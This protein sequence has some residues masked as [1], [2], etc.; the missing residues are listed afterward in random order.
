M[1][2]FSID[3]F[4]T[5]AGATDVG[6]RRFHN[7]DAFVIDEKIGLIA[8]ADGIG[9]RELGEVASSTAINALQDYLTECREIGAVESNCDAN[10]TISVEGKGGRVSTRSIFEQ[11]TAAVCYANEKIFALNQ[12]RGLLPDSSM[13]TT[14]TGLVFIPNDPWSIIA[15]NLGDSRLYRLRDR[16]LDQL[17]RD[18]T[19]HQDWLDS[20]RKG[21][22][23]L[24]NI[25]SQC[26]GPNLLVQ[27][28]VFAP[29]FRRG[30]LLLL[31]SDGLS[32]L[33]DEAEIRGR[34]LETDRNQLSDACRRLIALANDHGGKDNIT[35]V[36][37]SRE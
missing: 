16:Q 27:P 8:V 28:Y 20:G 15:F 23:P 30:D 14:L 4:T 17:S 37:V 25:L 6:L 35:V 19:L 34:M 29:A 33:V 9:G 12:D 18:D 2:T 32:D 31:C 5:A 13:G 11:T 36:L 22:E 21:N 1:K 24:R 10:S 3:A 7:E 26:V